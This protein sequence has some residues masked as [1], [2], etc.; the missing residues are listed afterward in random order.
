MFDEDSR[1]GLLGG[2]GTGEHMQGI[3]SFSGG[4]RRRRWVGG[5]A[6]SY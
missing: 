2:E 3:P 5:G 1:M 6:Q 4:H